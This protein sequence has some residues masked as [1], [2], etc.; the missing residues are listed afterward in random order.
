MH[1]ILFRIGPLT[2]H[3]Y[4]LLVAVGF[5]IGLFAIPVAKNVNLFQKIPSPYALLLVALPI[6]SAV[7]VAITSLVGRR[8]PLIWQVSKFGLIG[9][10]NTVVDF[11]ILNIL[12][13]A[14]GFDKGLPLASLNI[15][16]FS[17]AVTNSY[18]WNKNWVFEG[19]G[20][21]TRTEFMEF[22]VV[23]VIAA[24]V[25]SA[26]VGGVTEYLAPPGNLSSEQW[27]NVAKILA[28]IF[29]FTWNFLGYKF[30]VF[31]RPGTETLQ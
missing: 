7:G 12:I 28:V 5:L 19:N 22:A 1:P 3:T 26:I 27:A 10:L 21:K 9:V 17:V 8:I 31:R 23:S 13:F 29:S 15:V 16:S 18:L 20:K 11:G 24:V 25:S 30:I 6:A 14:T 2:I 4:G